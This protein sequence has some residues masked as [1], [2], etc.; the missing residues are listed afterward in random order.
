MGVVGREK[1]GNF[2]YYFLTDLD[3]LVVLDMMKKV[4]GAIVVKRNRMIKGE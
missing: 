4:V 3:L 2:I 1:K